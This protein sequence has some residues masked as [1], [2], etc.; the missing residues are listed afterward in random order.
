MWSFWVIARFTASVQ[1]QLWQQSAM[2]QRGLVHCAWYFSNWLWG[3]TG[4]QMRPERV[5]YEERPRCFIC[6]DTLPKW[7]FHL[8]R[9]WYVW[10]KNS[11]ETLFQKHRETVPAFKVLIRESAPG[12]HRWPLSD[13]GTENLHSPFEREVSPRLHFQPRLDQWPPNRGVVSRGTAKP[14]HAF[15]QRVRPFH[16]V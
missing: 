13:K 15:A 6:H 1:I 11:W 2:W 4:L 16:S 12:L 5:S 9:T 8:G 14:I 10:R 3:V 7:H